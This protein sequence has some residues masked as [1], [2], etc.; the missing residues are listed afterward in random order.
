MEDTLQL[1]I[2]S[3]QFRALIAELI[4]REFSGKYRGSF[5]GIAWAFAQ[6][7]FLLTIYTVALGGILQLRWANTDSTAEYGLALFSGLIVYLTFSEVLT[8]STVLI[9]GNPSLSKKVVFP[10]EL[11]SVVVVV[12]AILQGIVGFCV[13]VAGSLLIHGSLTATALFF[14]IVLA[15]MAPL[16]VGISWLLSSLC[17][18]VRDLQHVTVLVG[19]A[20]LFLTPIFYNV[21]MAPQ[22]FK[23]ILAINPLTL[24]VEQG[25]RVLLQ[26]LAPDYLALL[27]YVAVTS[28]F[29]WLSLMVFL[30]LRPAFADQV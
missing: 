29:A 13:W 5:G 12:T 18:W 21:E 22:A 8:K 25:R 17:V 7:L 26:G 6:P 14:P 11:L 4:K 23:P 27:L 20:F 2:R 9:T 19:H 24:I 28:I 16:L 15:C 30:R 10:L 3:W 1:L